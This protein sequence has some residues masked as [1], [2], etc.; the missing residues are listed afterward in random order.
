MHLSANE[1][2]VSFQF[3]YASQVIRY[4]LISLI[5]DRL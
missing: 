4:D 3:R 5:C 1:I 2:D